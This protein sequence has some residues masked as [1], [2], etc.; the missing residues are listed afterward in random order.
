[1]GEWRRKESQESEEFSQGNIATWIILMYGL[2]KA[3]LR[4][5]FSLWIFELLPG[6]INL[7]PRTKN[8]FWDKLNTRFK[9][10]VPCWFL[11]WPS[12]AEWCSQFCFPRCCQDPGSRTL[13]SQNRSHTCEEKEVIIVLPSDQHRVVSKD[14]R[15]RDG[16][17]SLQ[18]E[19]YKLCETLPCPLLGT[20]NSNGVY[21]VGRCSNSLLSYIC[22]DL[23]R[24]ENRSVRTFSAWI[25]ISS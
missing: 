7:E 5:S 9:Q 16:G 15:V 19:S 11:L 20:E 12:Y 14:E 24:K 21:L 23:D 25:L 10:T 8:M 4:D 17:E 2:M 1:M 13:H 3:H 22:P 6:L 18:G